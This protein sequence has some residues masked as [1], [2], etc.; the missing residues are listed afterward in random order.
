MTGAGAVAWLTLR[1][2]SPAHNAPGSGCCS[3]TDLVLNTLLFMP[4]GAGLGLLGLPARTA[5]V[6][7]VLCSAGVE[8]SQFWLVVGRRVDSRRRDQHSGSMAWR[9]RCPPLGNPGGVVA[10]RRTSCRASSRVVVDRGRVC[11][12]DLIA[13]QRLRLTIAEQ[14][15]VWLRL[16]GGLLCIGD[17]VNVALTTTRDRVTLVAGCKARRLESSLWLSPELY[18][19]ALFVFDDR[20]IERI[21]W[22][23]YAPGVLS[24]LCLGLGLVRRRSLLVVGCA[25]L[26]VGPLVMGTPLASSPVLMVALLAVLGGRILAKRLRLAGDAE[27]GLP[28][29]GPQ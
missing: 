27:L 19:G 11:R 23:S 22:W 20:G 3:A 25:A 12:T 4:F 9:D 6:V 18:W 24:F 2:G 13:Y 21:R 15:G 10:G 14:S 16:R 5:V 7:G 17:T 8:L 28:A 29:T 1:P 26:A